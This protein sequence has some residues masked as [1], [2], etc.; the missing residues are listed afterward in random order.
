MKK[1]G[2]QSNLITKGASPRWQGFEY[3]S[4]ETQLLFVTSENV[5]ENFIDVNNP[6]LQ[7]L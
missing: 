5:R 7:I 1:L 6:K 4:D 3:I 2:E